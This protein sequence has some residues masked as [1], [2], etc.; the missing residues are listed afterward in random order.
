MRIDL[1]SVRGEKVPPLYIADVAK[2]EDGQVHITFRV[3]VTKPGE[4][5]GMKTTID[6]FRVGR[7]Y[8]QERLW[9]D[10]LA[11][12]L[13]AGKWVIRTDAGELKL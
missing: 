2:V 8:Y 5:V 11:P 6:E 10:T 12:L 4:R 9:Q 1:G 3:Q 13:L 7:G